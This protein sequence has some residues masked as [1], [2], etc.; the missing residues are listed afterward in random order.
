MKDMKDLYKQSHIFF[1]KRSYVYYYMPDETGKYK[2]VRSYGCGKFNREKDPEKKLKLL[3]AHKREL[4]LRIRLGFP[5]D[6][7]MPKDDGFNLRIC[8]IDILERK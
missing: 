3:E 2:R 5:K 6:I 8:I 1:S 4:D 7:P